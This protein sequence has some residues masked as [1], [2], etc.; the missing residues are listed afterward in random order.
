MTTNDTDLS[1][2]EKTIT[3]ESWL[4]N[5]EDDRVRRAAL[6]AKTAV[7]EE[8]REEVYEALRN[9]DLKAQEAA[10]ILGIHLNT[11][12]RMLLSNRIPGAYRIGSRGD[13]RI[14][15]S[16]I[17]EFKIHGGTR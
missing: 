10:L 9:R 12:K 11:L 5:A 8:I 3:L 17:E 7:D 1:K 15:R 2:V 14:P 16:A 6:S 13:W 4:K